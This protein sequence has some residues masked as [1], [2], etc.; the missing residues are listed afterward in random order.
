M[1]VSVSRISANLQREG[2]ACATRTDCWPDQA[3]STMATHQSGSTDVTLAN[4]HAEYMQVTVA[5]HRAEYMDTM[6]SV[7][8]SAMNVRR[9]GSEANLRNSYK[10]V[11]L[12]DARYRV[13]VHSASSSS[14]NLPIKPAQ[15]FM[16]QLN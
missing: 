16:H 6:L 10:F 12:C 3:R 7:L 14:V 1:F 5:S 2:P 8:E 4:Q 9:P 13:V 15:K 11:I